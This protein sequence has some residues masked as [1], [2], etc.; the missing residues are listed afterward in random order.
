MLQSLRDRMSGVV[1]WFIVG[2]LIIPF[3]FFG[4][5][6]FT[7]RNANP[8]VASVGDTD[9]T[10]RE[11]RNAY[12]QR[13]QRLVQMLGENFDPSTLDRGVMRQ[14][15]LEDMIQQEARLQYAQANG[16][17]VSDKALMQFLQEVP[18]FQRDGQFSAEAYRELLAQQGMNPQRYELQL[19]EGLRAEQLRNAVVNSAFVVPEEVAR[20]QAVRDQQRSFAS[21]RVPASR[22]LGQIEVE[23]AALQAA[24][25][26][27][28]DAYRVPERVKLAYIELDRDSIA[29]DQP[30]PGE[31]VLK[32]L[33]ESESKVRFSSPERR[34]VRHIL[35]EGEN[36]R[37][38]IEEAAQRIE[39]GAS[40]AEVAE[41]VSDDS[42]SAE[43]GGSL[44][45]IER[46]DMVPAFE[47]VAFSLPPDSLSE[48]VESEFG[49]HLIR[50]DAVEEASTKAFD[51]PEVQQQLLRMYREREADVA[52]REALE[53]VERIAFE[54]AASLEPAAD[55][56]G[57][58]VKTTDMLTRGSGQ[59]LLSNPEVSQAAFSD[60]VSAGENSRPLELSPGRV[61][62]IRQREHEPARVR[63]LEEV[64]DKVAADVRAD[65]ARQ[66]AR[67]MAEAIV[68]AVESGGSLTDAAASR[69]LEP[70][71]AEKVGRGS[72]DW[73][74]RILS[75]VFALPRPGAVDSV[76]VR[77][78]DL[79]EE[80]IAVVLL[81]DVHVPDDATA[82]EGSQGTL[83]RRIQGRA[84]GVEFAGLEQHIIESIEVTRNEQVA[85][86]DE[87]GQPR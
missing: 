20:A 12:N 33:Y 24:Y 41:T 36:A 22:F 49:W 58:E 54:Q 32:R 21:V 18:A 81:Q 42:G 6:Q 39:E 63:P 48:P 30:E 34:Q 35:A 68:E 51:T 70:Q 7:T 83:T 87:G 55:A 67:E 28:R 84:A 19:R 74:R 37:D 79:G 60:A 76:P 82:D 71:V 57:L 43:D 46:G 5:D 14:A 69:D 72:N 3:A 50:V 64:R 75:T 86:L 11:F 47:E 17:R 1:A 40:F 65:R 85:E 26:S 13:Y 4:I 10:L 73:D 61:V 66:K 9:I 2:L 44:G 62:V 56:A 45:W 23:D 80:G 31:A 29:D 16:W 25:E 53:Q 77:T 27:N 52:F 78:V 38:R 59:G 8:E 15:V